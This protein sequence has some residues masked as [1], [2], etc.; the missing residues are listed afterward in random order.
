MSNK[1]TMDQLLVVVPQTMRKS[2]D[3]ELLN[4][5]NSVMEDDL[6]REA[7]KENFLGFTSVLVNTRWSIA[8]YTDAV[9]F[10]TYM[11]LDNKQLESYVKVFPDRYQN[12]VDKGYPSKDINSAVTAYSKSALV[13]K[14]KGCTLVPTHILN[15]DVY[16]KAINQLAHLM[17]HS[18]SEKVQG[19]CAGKLVEA[20]KVPESIKVEMDLGIKED[21]IM[22]VLRNQSAEL[23]KQQKL[24]VEA[25][26]V[27][28]KHVVEAPLIIENS[29]DT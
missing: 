16:Q 4:T 8:A 11:L 21:S 6:S 9:R 7:F 17:M 12:M 13:T 29:P 20:L 18:S 24:A 25:G 15:A 2:V 22:Q 26:A 14:I 19:D 28:L 23:V 27:T 3:V 1:L 10:V 5:I